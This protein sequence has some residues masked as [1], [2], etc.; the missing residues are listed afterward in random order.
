MGIWGLPCSR[1]QVGWSISKGDR[2]PC[3]LVSLGLHGA[4]CARARA[5]A[6]PHAGARELGE[7]HAFIVS[8]L[9]ELQD[10]AGQSIL[11]LRIQNPWGRRCWQGL[12]REG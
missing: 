11:L 7:F 4:L 2:G 9:R 12:W 6:I 3:V 10:Q 1:S 5:R 8:D